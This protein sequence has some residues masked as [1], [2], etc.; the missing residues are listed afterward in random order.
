MAQ[1]M[2]KNMMKNTIVMKKKIV[3]MK[4]KNQ[5]LKLN[6]FHQKLYLKESN[7][8]YYLLVLLLLKYC[9]FAI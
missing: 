2:M 4:K 9:K 7:F 1:N 3:I 6:L 8:L 5:V